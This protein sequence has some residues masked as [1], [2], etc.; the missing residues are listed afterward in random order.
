MSSESNCANDKER[1]TPV[2]HLNGNENQAS[3]STPIEPKMKGTV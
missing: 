1:E 3:T 2:Q